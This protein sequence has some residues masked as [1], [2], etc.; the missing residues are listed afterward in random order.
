[1]P[2]DTDHTP[3]PPDPFA[4]GEVA[5]ADRAEAAARLFAWMQTWRTPSGAYNGFVV[6]RFRN[7]RMRATHDTAWTQAAMIRGAA[8]WFERSGGAFWHDRMIEAADLQCRN[9][10]PESGRFI[11]AGHED[12]RFCSLVHC[13]LADI[14][15][16]HAARLVETGRAERY[17]ET[18]RKNLDRY[19]LGSLWVEKEGAF[20]FSEV[21]HWS[22]GEDRF[23][24]NFNTVGAQALLACSE[25]TGEPRYR[26]HALRIAEWLIARWK[27]SREFDRARDANPPALPEGIP[28]AAPGGLAYQFTP[29]RPEPDNRV[30][31]Y[32]GLAL[33]G[34]ASLHQHSRDPVLGKLISETVGYT[35]AMQDPDSGLFYHTTDGNSVVRWPQFV[36]GCGMIFAG[37]LESRR[38]LREPWEWSSAERAVLQRQYP[39]GSFPGFEGKG[40][41]GWSRPTWE[42]GVATPSWNAQMFEYL[43][44]VTDPPDPL[45]PPRSHRMLTRGFL[46]VDTPDSVHI[47]SWL[48]LDF[49]SLYSCR[50]REVRSRVYWPIHIMLHHTLGRTLRYVRALRRR[51]P[52][53]STRGQRDH[54]R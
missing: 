17:I 23:V 47:A 12:E 35:L 51:L 4:G 25:A 43:T 37:L 26:E 29:S 9:L 22:P 48:P 41:P 8:N 21:D 31:I 24:V 33:R 11:H 50:K 32:G 38:A 28:R 53:S 15:L 10:E 20:R 49:S 13:A 54:R 3:G 30:L 46:Y 6:H 1:M 40:R 5:D 36:A 27:F 45:P 44:L 18:A 42:D 2:S 16:L 52:T 7:K 14:A 34:L 39:N 19:C